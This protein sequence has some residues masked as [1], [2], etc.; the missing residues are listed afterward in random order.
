LIE[1]TEKRKRRRIENNIYFIEIK[2]I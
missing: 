1:N 2:Y